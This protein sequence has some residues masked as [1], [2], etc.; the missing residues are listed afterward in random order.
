MSG[1]RVAWII[2]CLLWAG[3]WLFLGFWTLGL[4][5]IGV[6]VS[7]LAILLPIGKEKR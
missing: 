3:L 5:W 1:P 2:F 7:L 6:P 4:A